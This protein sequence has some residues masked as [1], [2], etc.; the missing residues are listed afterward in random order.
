M[1]CR[2]SDVDNL[3][4]RVLFSFWLLFLSAMIIFFAFSNTTH[5]LDVF[6]ILGQE[7]V[8]SR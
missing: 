2:S 5:I 1:R 6:P 8:G 3:D 4:I 7:A